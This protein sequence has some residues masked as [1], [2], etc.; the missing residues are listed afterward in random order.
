MVKGGGKYG[1]ARTILDVSTYQLLKQLESF[2][3]SLSVEE[4]G[5]L[6]FGR[7]KGTASCSG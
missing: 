2:N 5:G 1:I 3:V 4:F 6:H 7:F